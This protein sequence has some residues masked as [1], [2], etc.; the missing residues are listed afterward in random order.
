MAQGADVDHGSV[1]AL[2]CVA[3]HQPGV[4]S[5]AIPPIAGLRDEEFIAKLRRYRDGAAGR[6]V[7][8]TRA[9]RL[10][11]REIEELARHFGAEPRAG[12]PAD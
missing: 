4:S 2:R 3:C 8:A 6:N 10:T 7:M 5:A 11:D 12:R 1:L 9:S